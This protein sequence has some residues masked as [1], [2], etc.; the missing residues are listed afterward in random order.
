MQLKSVVEQVSSTK[1]FPALSDH[2]DTGPR[3]VVIASMGNGGWDVAR[4]TRAE[5]SRQVRKEDI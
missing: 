4:E 3:V 1:S 2:V 5:I